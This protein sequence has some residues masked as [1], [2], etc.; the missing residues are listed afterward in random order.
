MY[1][2]NVWAFCAFTWDIKYITAMTTRVLSSFWSYVSEYVQI[3][4][5]RKKGQQQGEVAFNVLCVESQLYCIGTAVQLH[6]SF[7]YEIM[8]VFFSERGGLA[9]RE[10]PRLQRSS[11]QLT[12]K[13]RSCVGA[14]EPWARSTAPSAHGPVGGGYF[15]QTGALPTPDSCCIIVPY[16]WGSWPYGS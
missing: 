8:H 5:L 3:H 11:M 13:I 12:W 9:Q 16:M 6:I 2:G 1:V 4:F 7:M 10:Q 15:P 14:L